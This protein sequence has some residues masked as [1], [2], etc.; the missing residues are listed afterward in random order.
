MGGTITQ[1]VV[2]ILELRPH[3]PRHEFFVAEAV[4]FALGFLAAGDGEDL[5][6]DLAAD[7]VDAAAGE[8]FAGVDV[9]VVDHPLVHRRV[10]GDLDR[11]HRLAAEAT[12]AAGG[13]DHHV[14]AAGDDARDAGRVEAGRVH[15]DEALGGHRL[16][17]LID[18]DQRRR[19]A[20]GDGAER[21]FGDGGQPAFL[22]ADATDCCRASTPNRPVY[23]CH[24]WMRSIS[25]SATSG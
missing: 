17:V 10:G 2:A 16:G 24:H 12:A 6:E 1:I 25:L 22:V 18:L 11:R 5:L 20:F 4:E 13:E 3:G 9:H 23:H 14:G 8:D 21:F 7:V 15:E 19:A